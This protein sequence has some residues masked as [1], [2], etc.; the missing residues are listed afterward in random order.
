MKKNFFMQRAIQIAKNGLGYTSPNPMIGC[1]IEKDGYIIS[2]GWYRGRDHAEIEAINRVKHKSLLTKSTLYVTLEPCYYVNNNLSCI[3]LIIRNEIPR[4]VIGIK[5]P[6]KKN[7]GLGIKKLK[8]FGIEVIENLLENQC[9]ILNKRFFSFHEKKR[10]Y[11]ILKW[12]QSY[13]GFMYSFMKKKTDFPMVKNI[14]FSRQLNFKWRTEEDSFL[15]EGESLLNDNQLI[16]YKYFGNN[17][18]RIILDRDLK[19]STFS[20]KE[21]KETIVFTKKKKENKTNINFVQISFNRDK[22]KDIINYLYKKN[23][24]SL[25]VEGDQK[26]LN[27]FIKNNYWDESRIF[28]FHFF[29]KKGIHSPLINGKIIKYFYLGKDKVFFYKKI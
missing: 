3:D 22:I 23:I 4:V 2:E 15:V 25:I 6:C 10:P 14:S 12:G 13:N 9:R 11:I 16:D 20:L 18:I 28:I 1:V 24:L 26:T 29:L 5:N 8:Y 19:I 7:A 17:S 21:K 27:S